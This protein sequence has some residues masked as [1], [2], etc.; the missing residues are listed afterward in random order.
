[1]ALVPLNGRVESHVRDEFMKLAAE[2]DKSVS[3]LL[4][5]VIIDYVGS[6]GTDP[7]RDDLTEVRREVRALRATLLTSVS[8]L[9]HNLTDSTAEEAEQWVRTNLLE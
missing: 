4:R 7:V 8:G 2:Q 1:M 3:E 5:E 6:A 9:L